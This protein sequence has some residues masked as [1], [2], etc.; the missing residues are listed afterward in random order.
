MTDAPDFSQME[1]GDVWSGIYHADTGTW[2]WHDA[3]DGATDGRR[4]RAW[5]T[6]YGITSYDPER[7]IVH[8]WLRIHTEDGDDVS[9]PYTIGGSVESHESVWGQV[10]AA[11]G[12]QLMTG[13]P[14]LDE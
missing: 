7:D 14:L 3:R 6:G 8:A 13:I 11:N 1:R 2:D 9:L 5:A 4:V 12:Y 10:T